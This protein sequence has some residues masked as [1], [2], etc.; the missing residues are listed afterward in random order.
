MSYPDGRAVEGIWTQGII[1]DV[2]SRISE[3]NKEEPL[4]ERRHRTIQTATR[5]RIRERA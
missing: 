1:T 5:I 2:L 4:Q 3:A